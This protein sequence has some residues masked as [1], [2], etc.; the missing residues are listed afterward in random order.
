MEIITTTMIIMT[1][2]TS[3]YCILALWR[4][5]HLITQQHYKDCLH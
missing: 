1:A 4:A 5:H 3:S 2:I